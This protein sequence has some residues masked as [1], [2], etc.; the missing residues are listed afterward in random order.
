[1]RQ[2]DQSI[3][4]GEGNSGST[5]VKED[6]SKLLTESVRYY[7]REIGGRE[8]DG[9]AAETSR[10]NADLRQRADNMGS[11]RPVT[12]NESGQY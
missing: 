6:S 1:M 3:N 7:P 4:A 8:G 10:P 12:H 5:A 2:L 9:G 11:N